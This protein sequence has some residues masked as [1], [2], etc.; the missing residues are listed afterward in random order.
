MRPRID[1]MTNASDKADR[2]AP[3]W[4]ALLLALLLVLPG[5][6]A[7]SQTVYAGEEGERSRRGDEA[8]DMDDEAEE[9][10]EE[11]KADLPWVKDVAAAKKQ[12]A[13][14]GKDLFINFTGS[15]WCG[16]C[17]K[18]D[19]EVFTHA[20]FVDAATKEFVFLFLDFPRSD[21]LK[22]QVVDKEL[23]EKLQEAF[24]VAGFPTII[25]ATAD[26]KPYGRTGY[27]PGG[28]EAYLEHLVEMKKGGEAVK[29][30]SPTRS[31]RTSRCSRPAS[32]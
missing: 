3:S 32:R 18:L 14:E 21:E 25:L 16:W 7:T 20:S 17:H 29:T 11:A 26:G 4:W 31:T 15:D 28:P 30:C 1:D 19:D 27:Q 13:D 24:R 6:A 10:A 9:P 23:N 12:A 5:L 2:A 8:E 22:A